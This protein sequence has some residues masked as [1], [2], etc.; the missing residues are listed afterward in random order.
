MCSSAWNGTEGRVCILLA[1]HA[2]LHVNFDW[3]ANGRPNKDREFA[4]CLARPSQKDEHPSKSTFPKDE[5]LNRWNSIWA[6]TN[7]VR[8]LQRATLWFT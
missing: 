8:D 1:G 6:V 3:S 2:L 4:W 5:H 7:A